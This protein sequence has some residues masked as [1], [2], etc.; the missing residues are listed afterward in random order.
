MVAIVVAAV[1]VAEDEFAAVAVVV[2]EVEL[3]VEFYLVL[4][5]LIYHCKIFMYN[6]HLIQK[7]CYNLLESC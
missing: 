6:V 1:E 4:V 3:V 7:S 5:L 2:S